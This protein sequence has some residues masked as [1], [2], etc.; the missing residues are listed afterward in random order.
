VKDYLM[1][2]L[3]DKYPGDVK[4]DF[5][6]AVSGPSYQTRFLK[7][8]SLSGANSRMMMLGYSAEIMPAI[9]N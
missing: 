1:R 4:P 5:A 3:P 9:K 6:V 2:W 8:N 7:M